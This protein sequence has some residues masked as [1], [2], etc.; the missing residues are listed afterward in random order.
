MGGCVVL[1]VGLGERTFGEDAEHAMVQGR[2]GLSLRLRLSRA[3][4]LEA[5]NVV[6]LSTLS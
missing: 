1:A 4:R 3:A 6:T 2:Y 5:V